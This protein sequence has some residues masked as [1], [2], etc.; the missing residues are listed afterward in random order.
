MEIMADHTDILKKQEELLR[1]EKFDNN[2]AWK[3]GMCMA[4]Y[5]EKNDITIAVSII[6]M[7]GCTVFQHFPNGT[8][9]LNQKWIQRKFQTVKLTS[10]SSLL[11]CLQWEKEGQTAQTHG[12]C[13]NDYA[14]CGGGFPIRVKGSETVLGAVIAS[15][16][17]HM[18]DHGFVV[19]CLKEFLQMPDVEDFP[20]T[21]S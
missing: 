21:I 5:A 18:A 11:T 1:F 9:A 2:E 16:L 4:E 20:Y 12:V 19:N 13:E 10:Q 17:H 8:N 3:L 14:L 15:N 6:T 7:D